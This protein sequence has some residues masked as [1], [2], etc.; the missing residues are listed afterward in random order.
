MQSGA[1]TTQEDLNAAYAEGCRH[2]QSGDDA[3]AEPL[4]RKAWEGMPGHRRVTADLAQVLMRSDKFQEAAALAEAELARKPGDSFALALAAVAAVELG[5]KEEARRLLDFERLVRAFDVPVPDGF[6]SVAAFNKALCGEVLGRK[7]LANDRADRTTRGGRQSGALFPADS[8]ALAALQTAIGAAVNAYTT[9]LPPQSD[10]P[11]LA[12][13]PARVRL[14]GWATVLDA[15]GFQEPHLHPSGWL[16]GVYYA[17]LPNVTQDPAGSHSGWL[18]FG[19]P[20]SGFHPRAT[21]PTHSL[22]PREGQIVLFPS[23]MH[24]RT[25]PFAGSP[26]RISLAFDLVPRQRTQG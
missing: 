16:S 12:Q 19:E 11:F 5:E 26:A 17:R 14:H 23:Y 8:P 13:R 10:H 20:S 15:G 9:A 7:D 25:E 24:H 1:S 6:D 2:A 3:A 21:H 18:V 4:L 22:A